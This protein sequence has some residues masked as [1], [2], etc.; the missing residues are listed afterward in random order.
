MDTVGKALLL[1]E[2]ITSSDQSNHDWS[3][4][5]HF[6]RGVSSKG[7]CEFSQLI[8]MAG[9]VSIALANKIGQST[10]GAILSL[11]CPL[12]VFLINK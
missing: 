5:G 6:K 3:L 8:D 11:H 10:L 1:C 4:N 12:P 2:V 7:G 9:E